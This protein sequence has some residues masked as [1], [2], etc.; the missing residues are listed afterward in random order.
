MII[1][2]QYARTLYRD[3]Y[4]GYT[5]FFF[6]TKD[7]RPCKVKCVGVCQTYSKDMPLKLTGE[8]LSDGRF[9]FTECVPSVNSRDKMLTFLSGDSFKG[10]GEKTAEKIYDFV[11][12]DIFS[13]AFKPGADQALAKEVGSKAAREVLTKIR[14]MQGANQIFKHIEEFGGNMTHA[15]RIAEMVNCEDF[16]EDVYSIG[17]KAKMSFGCCDSIAKSRGWSPYDK[18]RMKALLEEAIDSMSSSGHSYTDIKSLTKSV[19]TICKSSAYTE[20]IPAP[21]ILS[22]ANNHLKYR[23]VEEENGIK[24]YSSYL[25]KSEKSAA[26]N[27]QRLTQSAISLPFKKEIVDDIEEDYG[28][29]YSESQRRS[30]EMLKTT[31]VKVLTGGP[32]TGK[33]TVIRGIIQAIKAMFPEEK[34]L[35]CAP[36]GRASQRLK[37]VTGE[38]SFTIHKALNLLPFENG[39]QSYDKIESKFIIIDEASMID[40]TLLDTLLKSVESSS[41]ILFCGDINQLPSVGPGNVLHDMI[42]SGKIETTTLDVVFRQLEDSLINFHAHQIMEGNT[43]VKEGKDFHFCSCST[44]EEM[45]EKLKEIT[46]ANYDENDIFSFQVLVPTKE[47]T[48]G[49][50]SLNRTL[51]PICNGYEKEP[52]SSVYKFKR[53]DKVIMTRNNYEAGYLNG[54]IGLVTDIT[55]TQL[56]ISLGDGKEIQIR[57][58]NPEDV[59]P[60]YALTVHKSQGSEFACVAIVLPEEPVCMLQRNLLYTAITRA[61]KEVFIIAQNDAYAQSIRNTRL[62]ERRTSLKEKIQKGD[63]NYGIE[64]E[65]S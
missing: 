60:A 10:V 7:I 53:F 13:F 48:A 45:V 62:A 33:S 9:S 31:G 46:R 4:T 50:R 65:E 51:Q 21:Y 19:N 25:Y 47:G 35:L 1:T 20:T 56:I 17:K 11:N 24:Y 16:L 64:S 59:S 3:E 54:D 37:E 39:T 8:L 5:T 12:G 44:E 58:D 61:K 43:D 28:I 52:V 41:L 42:A 57:K 27:I 30:F 6:N 15:I 18:K 26:E 29:T 49:V 34:P 55:D 22:F 14:T 32:G 63:K 23:I 38:D 40:I 36:T 2:G